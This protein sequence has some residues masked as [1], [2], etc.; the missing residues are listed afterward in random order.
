MRIFIGSSCLR[1][2]AVRLYKSE[3]VAY[4]ATTRAKAAKLLGPSGTAVGVA[5]A[6][7]WTLAAEATALSLVS[8]IIAGAA[9]KQA[10]ELLKKVQ[11]ATSV[12]LREMGEFFPV[13]QIDGRDL[14][15]PQAWKALKDGIPYVA[16]ADDFIWVRGEHG[17]L[18]IRWSAIQAV[19]FD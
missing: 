19:L 1:I 2:E 12:M 16:S 9:A 8:G 11:E 3:D 18:A 7:T 14:P 5:G 17:T 13:E 6:P 10:A 15:H 4:I